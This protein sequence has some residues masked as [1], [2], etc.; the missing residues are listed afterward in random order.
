MSES[1]TG[2]KYSDY[3]I[4][5]SLEKKIDI[6]FL[7]DGYTIEEMGKYRKDVDRFSNVLFSTSPYKENTDKF[8]IRLVESVSEESG[9]DIPMDNVWKNTALKTTYNT[10]GSERYLTTLSNFIVRDYAGVVPYDYIYIIVNSSKYGGGGVYNH[11]NVVSSDDKFSP[12]VFIH[13]FG[14]GFAGLADE[15]YTSSVSYQD[16]YNLNVEPVQPNITSLINFEKKWKDLIDNDIPIPTPVNSENIDKIGVYE[17]GGYV[18]KGIYRPY[19]DCMMKSK[20]AK[21][22]CPVCKKA[23]KYAI[24]INCD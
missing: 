13:E 17:G 24:L 4:N 11:I 21:E 12:F 14:H 6:V 9:T 8:N 19:I 20:T 18:S 10:F 22:F 5:G 23:I 15:Y 16:Y 3:I 7:A 1:K 2:I